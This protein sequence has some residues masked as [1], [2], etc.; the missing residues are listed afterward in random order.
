MGGIYTTQLLINKYQDGSLHEHWITFTTWFQSK[1]QEH[2]IEPVTKLFQ[3]LFHT[4]RSREHIVSRKDYELSRDALHRMLSDFSKSRQGHEL[5]DKLKDQLSFTTEL[6][7]KPVFSGSSKRDASNTTPPPPQASSSGSS[8]STASPP[9]PSN[10]PPQPVKNSNSGS[11]GSSMG[12]S[13]DTEVVVTLEP[14]AEQALEALM[15]EYEQELQTPIKG[16]ISGNLLTAVLIQMQK[17]KVHTEAAMLTM[18][19]VRKIKL[20]LSLYDFIYRNIYCNR[21]FLRMN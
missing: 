16:I 8:A 4:I 21:F 3:E 20:I 9:A 10:P 13:S 7:K 2:V 18:D 14:T 12:R 17:L 6:I 1:L 15:T 5:M 11:G 19:Q